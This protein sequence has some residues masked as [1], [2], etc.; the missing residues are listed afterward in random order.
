MKLVALIPA[1]GGSKGI[2]HKNMRLIKGKP[3]IQYTIEAALKSKIFSKVIVSTDDDKIFRFARKYKGICVQLRPPFLCNDD[4]PLLP[5]VHYHYN[6]IKVFEK[7]PAYI[8]VLQVTSPFRTAKHIQEAAKLLKEKPDWL[9]SI[10]RIEGEHPYR[11]RMFNWDEH[12]KNKIVPVVPF[13]FES[14]YLQRQDLPDVYKLNGA[15][16]FVSSRV[17]EKQ[18]ARYTDYDSNTAGYIMPQK[19]GLDIDTIEDLKRARK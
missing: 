19:A 3:M 15:I 8:C 4:T 5:I 1:R 14:K 6:G 9:W 11:M 13:L 10:S 17:L 16:W 18:H 12:I 2:K 7:A